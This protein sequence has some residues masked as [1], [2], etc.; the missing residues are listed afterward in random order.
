MLFTND[1][2]F[3][4]ADRNGFLVH[5]ITVVFHRKL[6]SVNNDMDFVA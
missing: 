1:L 3:K 4:L 5:L 6:S 2:C